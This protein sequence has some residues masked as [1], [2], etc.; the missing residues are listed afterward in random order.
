MENLLE[1]LIPVIVIISWAASKM[2]EQNSGGDSDSSREDSE[3]AERRRAIQEE[4]RRKIAERMGGAAPQSRSG[5]PPMPGAPA[6]REY[7]PFAP[8][9]SQR[10]YQPGQATPPPITMR[11]SAAPSAPSY[12]A[13]TRNFEEELQQQREAMAAARR[14][15]EAARR[16]A[17][18][19]L[20]SLQPGHDK[21]KHKHSAYDLPHFSGLSL[22]SE[23]KAMLQDPRA[24]RKAFL[25]AEIIGTPVGLRRDGEMRPSW[26]S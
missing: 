3:A 19:K 25:Q 6:Q 11:R 7:N 20:S 8:D 22:A 24:A 5:P 23:V 15:A 21:P 17:Q 12:E 18:A 26:K 14:Q 13:P 10:P 9:E 4:I 1:I 2:F 16:E